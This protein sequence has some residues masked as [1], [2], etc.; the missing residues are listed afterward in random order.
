[1]DVICSVI[2]QLIVSMNGNNKLFCSCGNKSAWKLERLPQS[3]FCGR[4]IPWTQF[5]SIIHQLK[6]FENLCVGMEIPDEARVTLTSLF[7]GKPANR[8]RPA[9]LT[10]A[11]ECRD[12][13]LLS[14]LQIAAETARGGTAGKE[15]LLACR[16]YYY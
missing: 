12:D 10:A 9:A 14:R 13:Q 3:T 4:L 1:M 5:F 7:S 6:S 2:H 15:S 8:L 16:Y 11:A